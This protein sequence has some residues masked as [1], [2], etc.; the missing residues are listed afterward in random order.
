MEAQGREEVWLLLIHDLGT[1]W[2]EW[3]ASR[4]GRALHTVPI[5]Q[6]AGRAPEPVWTQEVRGKNPFASA[7]NRTWIARPSSPY[8]DTILTELPWLLVT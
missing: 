6:E 8:P 5:G 1:R 2:G 3:S 4:P 7:G